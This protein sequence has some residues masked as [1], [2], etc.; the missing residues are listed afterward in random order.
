MMTFFLKLKEKIKRQKIEKNLKKEIEK[1]KMQNESLPLQKRLALSTCSYVSLMWN[2]S[3]QEFL[4]SSLN[5]IYLVMSGKFPNVM[6]SF[7]IE[8]KE[9]GASLDVEDEDKLDVKAMQQ[10]QY[11]LYEEV[12]RRSMVSPTFNEVYESII[13]MRKE[14]N[15]DIKVETIRDVFPY[16]FLEDLYTYHL[17]KWETDLKKKSERLILTE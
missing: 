14:R 6:L 5:V 7:A 13:E 8:L 12:A 11:A 2:G 9:R 16:D 15:I 10:E 4:I 1:K 3:L 17:K